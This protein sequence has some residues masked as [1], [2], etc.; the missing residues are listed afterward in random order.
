[1]GLR[2]AVALQSGAT[3]DVLVAAPRAD[4]PGIAAEHRAALLLCQAYL[5]DARPLS[6]A[7]AAEVLAVFSPADVVELITR[8]VMWSSDKTLV[9]L[10]LDLDAP[11]TQLY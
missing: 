8:L 10:A 6:P 3:E 5:E 1:M 2:N 4:D 11:I 9:A 7:V